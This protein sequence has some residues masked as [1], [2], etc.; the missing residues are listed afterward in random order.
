MAVRVKRSMSANVSVPIHD[1][2]AGKSKVWQEL[3]MCVCKE[4]EGDH[5]KLKSLLIFESWCVSCRH[6]VEVCT[7]KIFI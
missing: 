7:D 6:I 4:M 3:C 2:V 1:P 5:I